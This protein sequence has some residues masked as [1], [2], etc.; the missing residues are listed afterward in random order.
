MTNVGWE[1]EFFPAPKATRPRV[2]HLTAGDAIRDAIESI[3]DGY[4]SREDLG[5][6]VD[7]LVEA[8]ELLG[9]RP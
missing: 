7:S 3:A 2:F 8:L 5:T 6:A 4:A 9:E 1:V